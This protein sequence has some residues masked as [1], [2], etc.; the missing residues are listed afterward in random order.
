MDIL[1]IKPETHF[2]DIE[3]GDCF[4]A[5]TGKQTSLFLKIEQIDL[6]NKR[7]NAIRLE[8]GALWPF[9]DYSSIKKVKAVVAYE[10]I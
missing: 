4:L 1:N 5:F 2:E 6:Y 3:I 9:Q 8:D 7:W 10:E